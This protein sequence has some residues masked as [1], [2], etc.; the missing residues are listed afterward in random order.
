MAEMAGDAARHLVRQPE[1][2]VATGLGDERARRIDA[3]TEDH[4]LVDGTLQAER[5]AASVADAGEAA[6]QRWPWRCGRR[7]G[8]GSCGR[9][10]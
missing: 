1:V 9:R 3:R 10:S 8:A 7:P 6:Q 4:A 2:A 5:R